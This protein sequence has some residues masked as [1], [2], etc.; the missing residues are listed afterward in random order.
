MK[1][2]L[3]LVDL[4][5]DFFPG[6]ALPVKEGDAILPVI[7]KLLEKDWELVIASVDWHPVNHGSFATTHGK[8]EG[9]VITLEGLKQTLW[10]VHCVQNTPGAQFAPGWET[11]KIDTIFYKG[12]DQN[13]DSYSTFFDNGHR[14]STGLEQYLK[15]NSV[16]DIYLV[17]LAT[18]YC[19]KYS[20]LD[21]KK[22]GFNTFVILDGCRGI[23]LKPNDVENAIDEMKAVGVD[24]IHYKDMDKTFKNR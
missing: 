13:I 1:K 23:D 6:G 4:Q 14:K 21:A 19:V 17:G 10:P 15:K 16:T 3:L 11:N 8:K 2:A 22:L 24:L 18:D 9:D 5:N 20:A 12:T 7:N